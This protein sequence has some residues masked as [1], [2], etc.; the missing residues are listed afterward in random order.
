ML[1]KAQSFVFPSQPMK[2]ADPYSLESTLQRTQ[3]VQ[4]TQRVRSIVL[5]N[6]APKEL[7]VDQSVLFNEN[8]MQTDD[9]G[10]TEK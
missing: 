6:I 5:T 2:Q 4:V 3:G 1:E 10:C 9:E 7:L 8:D